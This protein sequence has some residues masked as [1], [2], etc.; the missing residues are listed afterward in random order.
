MK[1]HLTV[2]NIS[3]GTLIAMIP[4]VAGA[5]VWYDGLNEKRHSAIVASRYVADVDLDL[6]LVEVELKQ[7][8]AIEERRPLTADEQDRKAYLEERRR[9]LLAEQQKGSA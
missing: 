6:R 3:L 4:L 7:L 8:R 1:E 2:K 5:V 9:I